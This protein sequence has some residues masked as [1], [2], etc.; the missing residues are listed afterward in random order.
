VIANPQ[1]T[2][3]LAFL[4]DNLPMRA[5][6]GGQRRGMHLVIA[7]RSD[8]RLPLSRLRGRGLLTEIEAADLRFTLDEATAFLNQVMGL[9]LSREDVAALAMRTEGWI[10]GLQMVAHALQ[11]TLSAGGQDASRVSDF[12]AAFTGS[13]RY[14]LDY[15]TDEVL[16]QEPAPTQAFL[17]RTSILER[18]SG[19]LCDAVTGQEGGQEMLARLDADNLFVVPLDSERHWYRYHHLFANLLGKRL[20][21]LHADLV[22]DLHRRASQWYEGAGLFGEAIAHALAGEDYVRAA[23]LIERHAIQQLSTSRREADLAEW[24]EALPEDLV[25]SRPWLCV[26]IAWTRHWRGQRDQVEACLARAE[27]ALARTPEGETAPDD[28][29]RRE[30]Q[31]IAGYIAA[32]RAHHALVN[33]EI[34]RVVDMA[35][36]AIAFL[37]EGDYMR[38]EAAVAL[39]GAYWALGDVLA[40]RQAFAQARTTAER[41]GYPPLAVPAGCYEGMQAI[42]QGQLHEAEAIFRQALHRAIGPG[43]RPL[44]V[45]GFPL[46]RLGDLSREWNDLEA[47]DCDLSKGV[48]L[49][50]QLGQ[51]DVIAEGYVMLARLQLAQGDPSQILVT[52]ER[53]DRIRKDTKIDPWIT[54][55]AD[56]C[57]IQAWLAAG[58]LAAATRWAQASGLTVNDE[59]AYQ[60]DLHHLNLARVLIAQGDGQALDLLAR[61]RAAAERAGWVHEQIKVLILEALA[62][63]MRGSDDAQRALEALEQALALAEPGGY[64]RTFVQEGEPLTRLLRQVPPSD[65]VSRLLAACGDRPP[66]PAPAASP[67]VPEQIEPLSERETEVLALIAQGLTNREV[68]QR[69]FI[70]Q[71]TVKAHT[72]NIYGKLGVRSRTQAVARARELGIL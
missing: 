48:L 3:G 12:I 30:E 13:H 72:S 61:L 57:R 18:L 25:Q 69:L 23:A 39:G 6:P 11:G 36:R 40:S 27:R 42:K 55:W 16:L 54:S 53:V 28:D 46:V 41:S 31:L 33:Q 26:Y 29:A 21:R 35:Q 58:D 24:L 15:L 56:E 43:D 65:Y 70:S 71:G 32:I 5:D 45:A 64:L 44:P 62:H 67:G 38:C 19:P 9:G 34:P 4:L 60:Y 49:C 14:I 1:V 51:A 68:G 22:P 63:Q 47:A 52:L 50:R 2:E 17:L 37:S 8:P 59:P 7:T 10:V 66:A 20:A